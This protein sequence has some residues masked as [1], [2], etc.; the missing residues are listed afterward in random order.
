MAVIA[1]FSI[2]A[3]ADILGRGYAAGQRGDI[4]TMP[5]G[6]KAIYMP[7]QNQRIAVNVVAVRFR[8]TKELNSEF[9]IVRDD[10]RTTVWTV[11]SAL[12]FT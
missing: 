8:R 2:V 5:D 10:D 7:D 6:L 4:I 11:E 12:N 9:L 3:A 1:A